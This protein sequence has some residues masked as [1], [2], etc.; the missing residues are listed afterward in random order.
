[1]QGKVPG[2]CAGWAGGKSL[3]TNRS[4]KFLARLEAFSSGC[5]KM[6]LVESSFVKML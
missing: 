6:T 5:D 4:L 3:W 2:C 1:M